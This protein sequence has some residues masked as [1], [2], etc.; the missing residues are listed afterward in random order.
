VIVELLYRRHA[1]GEFDARMRM[2]AQP[3]DGHVGELVLLAL[4]DIGKAGVV[5][6]HAKIELGDQLAAGPVPEAEFRLDEAAARHLVDEPEIVEHFKRCR[7]R[8]CRAEA[9]VHLRLRLEY[10]HRNVLAHERQR[11]DHAH[12]SAA[13]D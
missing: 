6:E 12:R 5:P 10:V 8:R 13:S 7:V 4:D 11:H 3:L 9:V 2:A 1:G